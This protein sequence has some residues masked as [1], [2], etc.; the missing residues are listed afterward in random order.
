MSKGLSIHTAQLQRLWD[1]QQMSECGW[2]EQVH[3]GGHPVHVLR[4]R[5]EDGK[6][7]ARTTSNG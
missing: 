2:R 3:G 4:Q 7:V 1:D 5:R 6:G